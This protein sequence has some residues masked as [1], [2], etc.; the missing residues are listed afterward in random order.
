MLYAGGMVMG[1]ATVRGEAE[2]RSEQQLA[3]KGGGSAVRAGNCYLQGEAGR[4][5]MGVGM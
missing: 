1:M 3:G 5:G 4:W 2:G